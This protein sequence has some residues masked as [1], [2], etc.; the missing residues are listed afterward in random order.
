MAFDT[1][2][3]RTCKELVKLSKVPRYLAKHGA[4]AP[5]THEGKIY[6]RYGQFYVTNNFS[7]VRVDWPEYQHAGDEEWVTL[8]RFMDNDGR[9]CEFEFESA[10][11]IDTRYFA[12]HF[13]DRVDFSE[14]PPVNAHLL[15]DVLNIFQINDLAPI[16]ACD[17]SKWELIAHNKDVSIK[18]LVMGIRR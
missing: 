7:L 1:K 4:Y 18:A 12:K 5:R 16:L 10:N 6:V 8:S 15:R 9:L 11:I 3:L 2:Q 17:S 14:N 13:I